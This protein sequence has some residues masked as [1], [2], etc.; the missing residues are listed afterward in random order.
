MAEDGEPKPVRQDALVELFGVL[1]DNIRV[2][3]LNAC[4]S[5]PQAEAI[6][7]FIDCAI[8]MNAKSAMKRRLFLPHRFTGHWDSAVTSR[9]HSS[10][11]PTR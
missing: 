8:G 3:V 10:W 4:H 11:A 2:V 5:R 1:P 7:Q 6:S 9:R